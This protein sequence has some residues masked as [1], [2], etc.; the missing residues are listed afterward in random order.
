M[1]IDTGETVGWRQFLSRSDR[2][3]IYGTAC[4]LV[5]YSR[6]SPGDTGTISRIANSLAQHQQPDG[7]WAS[8]TILP[9]LSLTTATCYAT[10]A[11]RSAGWQTEHEVLQGA[12]SWLASLWAGSGGIG[13][14]AGDEHPT[15]LCSALTLRALT[16][17]GLGHDAA[18]AARLL[19]WLVHQQ[20]GDG[21]FGPVPQTQST[22]HHTAEVVLAFS[23]TRFRETNA[24]QKAVDFLHG[25]WKIGANVHRDISYVSDKGRVAM[26]PHTYQTDGL[27]L[28]AQMTLDD[29]LIEDRTLDLVYELATSQQDGSWRHDS[30]PDKLPA[31]SIMECV[32]GL[33]EFASSVGRTGRIA[34]LEETVRNLSAAVEQLS[35]DRA[36]V[37]SEI[38]RHS[39]AL[40]AMESVWRYRY[41]AITLYLGS[42]YVFLRGVLPLK[43]YADIIAVLLGVAL[44]VI[45]LWSTRPSTKT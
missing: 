6:L 17:S 25:N 3:G 13:N 39:S 28:E 40:G 19:E 23:L 35:A 5:A 44:T 45:Q 42:M 11:L 14:Y 18:P 2:T 7:G 27:L 21:G 33:S 20:N 37:Q 1:L 15:I 43:Q 12:R 30:I 36:Y 34:Y 26:L 22:L 10:M 31:W 38:D 16:A 8:D 32:L 41:V 9:G 29:E 4:G 24:F